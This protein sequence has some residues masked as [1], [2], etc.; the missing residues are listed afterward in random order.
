MV[1]KDA[2]MLKTL[3]APGMG[4]EIKQFPVLIMELMLQNPS[5]TL[6][7]PTWP[8]F[9]ALSG[10]SDCQAMAGTSFHSSLLVWPCQNHTRDSPDSLPGQR[11]GLQ[12][13]GCLLGTFELRMF[14][15]L[16][17]IFTYYTLSLLCV[18]ENVHSRTFSVS[19]LDKWTDRY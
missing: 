3:K 5:G 17:C 9:Q 18:I 14:S 12:H 15:S 1:I 11:A 6:A 13:P 8:H 4:R 10:T 16:I 2:L 19:K 7:E